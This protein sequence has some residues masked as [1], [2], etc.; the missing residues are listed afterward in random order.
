MRQDMMPVGLVKLEGLAKR[1]VPSVQCQADGEGGLKFRSW[2]SS[3]AGKYSAHL[4]TG[5]SKGCDPACFLPVV[6][7]A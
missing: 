2:H 3:S 7:K 6:V 5:A 1:S 4:Q